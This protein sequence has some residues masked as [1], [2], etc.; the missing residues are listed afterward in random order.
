M[1]AVLTHLAQRRVHH[2]L[3]RG[4]GPISHRAGSIRPGHAS[5]RPPGVMN[6]RRSA[7]EQYKWLMLTGAVPLRAA[8]AAMPRGASPRTRKPSPRPSPQRLALR[9]VR[10]CCT[11]LDATSTR[12]QR[13]IGERRDASSNDRVGMVVADTQ[14]RLVVATTT[15]EPGPHWINGLDAFEKMAKGQGGEPPPTTA[16]GLGEEAGSDEGG[17]VTSVADS[18]CEGAPSPRSSA[19]EDDAAAEESVEV[20]LAH[21]ERSLR[22]FLRAVSSSAP[23]ASQ[24]SENT[25]SPETIEEAQ[26][27]SVDQDPTRGEVAPPAN[28]PSPLDA[29]PSPPPHSVPAP[30]GIA[31]GWWDWLGPKLL[32]AVPAVATRT[33]PDA[34]ALK[35]ERLSGS[36]VLTW[37]LRIVNVRQPGSERVREG[38]RHRHRAF[39]D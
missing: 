9:P 2:C 24:Y 5:F 29:A 20:L 37:P 21:S 27:L 18:E 16:R 38:E 26:C 35:E 14:G 6:S 4:R 19:D 12:Q 7:E 25:A 23:P 32:G 39:D 34:A 3:A 10:C 28:Q 8:P 17:D 1:K 11:D 31:D 36:L 15:F 30:V 33:E 22:G 13:S